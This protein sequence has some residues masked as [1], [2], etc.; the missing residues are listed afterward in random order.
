MSAFRYNFTAN[1]VQS[2]HDQRVKWSIL[3]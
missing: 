3:A 2:L 1:S